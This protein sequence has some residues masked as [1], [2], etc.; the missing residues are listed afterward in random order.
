[1]LLKRGADINSKAGSEESDP[2]DYYLGTP[3]HLAARQH[4]FLYTVRGTLSDWYPAILQYKPAVVETL[5]AHGARTDL[6]DDRG[7]TPLHH[8]AEVRIFEDS[9]YTEIK[10]HSALKTAELLL[11]GGAEVNAHPEEGHWTP[12][13]AALGS[14][15]GVEIVTLLLNHGADVEIG[16][17]SALYSASHNYAS[18]DDGFEV[19]Q[20][21]LDRGAAQYVN[22][23]TM[24][25]G[26]SYFSPFMIALDDAR[27][28]VVELFVEHGA[29]VDA[30]CEM[31]LSLKSCSVVG[32]GSNESLIFKR[33]PIHRAVVNEDSRITRL[34]LELGADPDVEGV[35]YR[36]PLFFAANYQVT[37]VL[38]EYGA[39]PNGRN[40]IGE[41]PLLRKA[42]F[43]HLDDATERTDTL[44]LI[45]ALLEYG[46]HVDARSNG[47]HNALHY[48]AGWNNSDPE[49]VKFFLDRGVNPDERANNGKTPCHIARETAEAIDDYPKDTLN[50]F[51]Q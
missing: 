33:F 51:C 31:E 18:S 4:E 38:L 9:S 32:G 41:T 15:A 39:N 22:T 44:E 49:L 46:A 50:L 3:L 5:L 19:I 25:I 12:L 14:D 21:L 23:C 36:N 40:V 10:R 2:S 35:C 26:G 29:D 27:L 42:R 24:T 16:N 43:S 20:L 28:E 47:G 13:Y 17:E 6:E 45:E 7:Y 34:L 8:A 30:S 11:K 1:M 48:L 37:K